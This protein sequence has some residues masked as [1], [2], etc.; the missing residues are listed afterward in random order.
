MPKIY[1]SP[2][3]QPHNRYC[4][5]NTNEKAEMEALAQRIKN[6]L[7]A[8]YECEPVMATLS[9]GIGA[10]ERPLEAKNKGC[11]V[12]LAIHSNAGGGGKASGAVAFYHPDSKTGKALATAI[13]KELGAICP[14]A[15]NRSN[16]V[17]NGMLAFDGAGYGE[18][19][20]PTSYGL[21]SVLAE[22]DF[23]DNPATAQWIVDHIPEIATAYAAALAQVLNISPKATETPTTQKYY[24]VQVGA[25]TVKDN[26]IKM[27]QHLKSH[28]I[29]GYIKYE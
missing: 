3:N 6:I 4:V 5:G 22:T 23:H 26:A 8:E 10:K 20:T 11:D 29:D 15:S 21:I 27:Q 14:I 2:S 25:F 7:D 19:R 17:A 16:P 9:M 13:A 1:L 12:Y 24:K 28:G 18:V